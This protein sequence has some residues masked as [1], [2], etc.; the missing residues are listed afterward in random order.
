MEMKACRN[1]LRP[2]SPQ[3]IARGRLE[4]MLGAI[5]TRLKSLVIEDEDEESNGKCRALVMA[6]SPHFSRRPLNEDNGEHDQPLRM[7]SWNTNHDGL[8]LAVRLTTSRGCRI[9]TPTSTMAECVRIK[10]KP[11]IQHSLT[12]PR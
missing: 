6:M 8:D 9:Q 10:L 11:W 7:P 5:V 12:P 4:G 3:R 1:E 2:C